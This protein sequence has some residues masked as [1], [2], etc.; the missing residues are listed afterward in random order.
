MRNVDAEQAQFALLADRDCMDL[1]AYSGVA[2]ALSPTFLKRNRPRHA[3]RQRLAPARHLRSRIQRLDHVG[4][5]GEVGARDQL[6]AIKVWVLASS[7]GKLIH[8]ALAIK[9]VRRLAD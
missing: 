7:M 1:G 9:I 5:V 6:T 3:L 2:T 8:E 4:L